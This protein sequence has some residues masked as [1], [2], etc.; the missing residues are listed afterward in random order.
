MLNIALF[1]SSALRHQ[2][3][4]QLALKSKSLRVSAIFYEQGQMLKELVNSNPSSV[5]EQQHLHERDQAEQDYFG[6][7]VEFNNVP[8]D[9]ARIVPRGW[10]STEE[11]IKS[12]GELGIDL[13]LV[14]GTSIIKGNLLQ[15]YES[16]IL[17]LHLGLSPYYRGGGTNYFPFVNG[18]PEFCGATY[19]FLD[20]GIDTGRIIHQNR[21]VILRTDS[22]HQLSNRFLI[23][24]FRTYIMLVERFDELESE[25]TT[26][27][28]GVVNLT[29]K[30]YRRKDFTRST[31]ERLYS[32][33]S[34]GM[35]GEYLDNKVARDSNVPLTTQGF[36]QG[37][38]YA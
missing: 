32:N 20:E 18:E 7:F 11:C 17:N 26:L 13:I 38:I 29:R 37:T 28:S 25:P 34:D 3:F 21:P 1:T 22:F 19:M 2:A 10:F 30:V 15:L 31:V 6:L 27:P 35:I 4:A 23:R 16:R 14:Y 24:A 33:I 12:L 36:T 9:T 5:I 8:A